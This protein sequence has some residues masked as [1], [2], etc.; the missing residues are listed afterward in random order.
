MA[1]CFHENG[2]QSE[3][4]GMLGRAIE[5]HG[6]KP[7]DWVVELG[8]WRLEAGDRDG[9]LADYHL[10]LDWQ[11]AEEVILDRIELVPGDDD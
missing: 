4:I 1:Q 9:A 11:P 2:S 10:A 5:F 6:G 8:D 3:A 7:W